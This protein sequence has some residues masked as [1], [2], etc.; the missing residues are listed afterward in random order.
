MKI[1]SN[2]ELTRFKEL[3]YDFSRTSVIIDEIDSAKE[4]LFETVLITQPIK[5]G[6]DVEDVLKIVWETL[7]KRS[8]EFSKE[9]N[10]LVKC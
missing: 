4:K 10:K 8:D 7:V 2:K 3:Q 1:L 5:E 6:T 9:A